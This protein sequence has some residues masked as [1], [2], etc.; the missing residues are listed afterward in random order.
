MQIANMYFAALP[1]EFPSS[2]EVTL[3]LPLY[4]PE[5][6]F[7]QTF[8][9]ILLL[10]LF[11]FPSNTFIQFI[12]SNESCLKCRSNY[13]AACWEALIIQTRKARHI[14]KTST[15][16]DSCTSKKF[17]S[18][19]RGLKNGGVPP[20]LEKYILVLFNWWEISLNDVDVCKCLRTLFY[21]T[22]ANRVHL[23]SIEVKFDKSV[24]LQF[25]YSF[26]FNL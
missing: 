25:R 5:K 21:S 10:Q 22:L 23:N 1:K 2:L 7:P 15:V 19:I 9:F 12:S 4:K 24:F 16:S 6:C 8:L 17:T 13:F 26:R 3:A 11:S 20:Q 18:A 14:L